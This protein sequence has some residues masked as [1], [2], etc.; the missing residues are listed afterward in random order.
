MQRGSQGL[1]KG[2]L[3]LVRIRRISGR[4]EIASNLCIRI[5]DN[6]IARLKLHFLCKNGLG[7]FFKE[8]RAS[9]IMDMATEY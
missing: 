3:K 4:L 1:E 5:T 6:G 7:S 2:G 9:E 8:L